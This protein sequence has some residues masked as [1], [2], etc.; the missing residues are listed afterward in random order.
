MPSRRRSDGR[1]SGWFRPALPRILAHR[2]LALGVPEN[3]L[4]SFEKAISA[5]VDY[6]ET[7]VNA[8]ADGV[9]IVSHDPTLERLAGRPERIAELTLEQLLGIDLGGGVRFVTLAD[10]LAAHPGV[11]F[12]IDIKSDDVAAPAARAILD[13]GASDRVLI[14]SFSTRR[15]RSAVDLLEAG[16]NRVAASASA[17]EFVPALLA[18]KLGLVP[19]VRLL[20]RRVDAVQIPLTVFRMRTTTARMVR[21]LH[22]A[23]VEVHVWTINDVAVARGL[24]ERGVNGIVTD[25]AD[26]MLPLARE[27]RALR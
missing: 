5:G 6:L 8:S 2:G 14:T 10:V 9:A 21:R 25:R 15:R 20:L 24:L 17:G 4:A 3:T 27:F 13:A 23:G 18:A 12:N 11:R 7:D 22:A 16:G 26:L 1:E 19:L